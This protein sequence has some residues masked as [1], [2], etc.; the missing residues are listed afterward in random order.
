MDCLVNRLWHW[1][2]GHK[3]EMHE[4]EILLLF[5]PCHPAPSPGFLFSV[6]NKVVVPNV[7]LILTLFCSKPY[8]NSPSLSVKVV[9][10]MFLMAYE[11]AVLLAREALE[12]LGGAPRT[13]PDPLVS[14][15]PS[16]GTGAP[17]HPDWQGKGKAKSVAF[18]CTS[19]L[20]ARI[21]C[22]AEVDGRVYPPPSHLPIHTY[23]LRASFC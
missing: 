17:S 14:K 12:A 11:P 21:L 19:L 6:A 9:Q 1:F 3:M 13:L 16:A 22:R 15:D 23:T 10:S 20:T 5:H 4:M 7:I 18:P 8:N 2:Y